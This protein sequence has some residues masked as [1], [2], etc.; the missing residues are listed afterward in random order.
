MK[1]VRPIIYRLIEN[2]G[3]SRIKV[4]RKSTVAY[5]RKI[6]PLDL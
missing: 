5:S 1:S 3:G 4:V 6:A 2:E